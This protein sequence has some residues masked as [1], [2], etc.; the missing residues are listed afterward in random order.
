MKPYASKALKSLRF[1][2]MASGLLMKMVIVGTLV[3]LSLMRAR[4]TDS[5]TPIARLCKTLKYL[6]P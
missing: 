6:R 1:L 3:G 5:Y 4:I 2:A